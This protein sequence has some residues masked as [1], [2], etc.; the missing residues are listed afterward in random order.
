MFALLP[1]PR[2]SLDISNK[3]VSQEFFSNRVGFCA[4]QFQVRLHM[5][6]HACLLGGNIW[7]GAQPRFF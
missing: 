2:S 3:R 5:M 7:P 1:F 6:P 4:W